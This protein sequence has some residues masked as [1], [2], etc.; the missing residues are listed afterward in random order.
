MSALNVHFIS[1]CLHGRSAWQGVSGLQPRPRE[2]LRGAR[3][4]ACGTAGP[5]VVFSVHGKHLRKCVG[6]TPTGSEV[7]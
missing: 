3:A 2:V 5:V 4:G 7:P 1:Y 6:Q